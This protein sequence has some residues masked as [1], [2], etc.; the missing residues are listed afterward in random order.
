M[1]PRSAMRPRYRAPVCI[2]YDM[3]ESTNTTIV[4][5]GL[6]LSGLVGV[7]LDGEKALDTTAI[8]DAAVTPTRTTFVDDS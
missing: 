1:V 4:V 2:L 5:D 7:L 8:V 6:A 3:S